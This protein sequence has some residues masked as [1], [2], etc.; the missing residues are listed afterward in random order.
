V[1]GIDFQKNSQIFS[2]SSILIEWKW[3][4]LTT[5]P[6]IHGKNKYDAILP[7]D[8]QNDL[9]P[10]Y[11]PIVSEIRQKHQFKIHK[12]FG[13]MAS[14]QAACI[15]LFAPVLLNNEVANSS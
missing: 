2:L 6:G 12:H 4:H 15:N 8:F 9:H 7:K 11:R 10:L 13:H 3:E 1:K 5:E 14:S